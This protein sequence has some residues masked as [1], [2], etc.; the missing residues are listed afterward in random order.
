MIPL[1]SIGKAIAFLLAVYVVNYSYKSW[2]RTGDKITGYV[3]KLFISLA[4]AYGCF[5]FFPLIENLYIIQAILYFV[6]FICFVAMGYFLMI[7]LELMEWQKFKKG[8]FSLILL[9]GVGLLVLYSFHFNPAKIYTFQFLNLQFIGWAINLP[10]LYR[11]V[12]SGLTASFVLCIPLLL[13]KIRRFKDPFIRH[14]AT[15]FSL[16]LLSLIIEGNICFIYGNIRPTSF[17][18]DLAHVLFSILP[19]LCFL[20]LIFY[21]K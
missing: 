8:I 3:F 20:K 14:R 21:K 11:V 17:Y 5:I 6:E 2:K 12:I 7:F 13:I 18:K 1:V 19:L 16:G 10:A 9:M 4:F 15:W